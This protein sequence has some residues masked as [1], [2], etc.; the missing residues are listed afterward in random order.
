MCKKRAINLHRQL[1]TIE[2]WPEILVINLRERIQ[3]LNADEL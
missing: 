3:S 1:A 2:K